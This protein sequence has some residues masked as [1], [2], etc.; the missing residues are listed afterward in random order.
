MTLVLKTVSEILAWKSS[1][2]KTSL[3]KTAPEQL[4]VGFV[5]TMGALHQ[6]HEKLLEQAR[7]ENDLVVLSVF[8]NPTQFN[9]PDD[10]KNYPITWDSDLATAQRLGVDVVFAPTKAELYP[11]GYRYRISEN[12]LSLKY[13]GAHRPGHFDGVLSVVAKLFQLISPQKAYFGEKDYQQLQ[14]VQGL[15]SAFFMDLKVISVP[16]LRET[17]GLAMSSRNRLLS[18]S[19]REIAPFLFKALREA[20]SCESATNLLNS[21]GFKV[22]YVEEFNGRRLAAAYLGKVRLIDNVQI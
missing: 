12:D 19:D 6:G 10:L 4:S 1:L 22:D 5:P 2:R 14:L 16:T 21:A 7:A 18:P 20:P 8:V 17:D 3:S 15:V 11:D 9:N 13:C